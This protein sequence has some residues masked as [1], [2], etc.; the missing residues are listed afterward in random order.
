VTTFLI[1]GGI[2]LLIC[3]YLALDWWLAGRK[4]KRTLSRSR[5]GQIGNASVDEH[6]IERLAQNNRDQTGGF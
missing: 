2:A 5:D 6:V 1:V 3:G 4:S